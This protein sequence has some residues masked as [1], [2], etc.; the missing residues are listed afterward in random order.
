MFADLVLL[1]NSR[2]CLFLGKLKSKWIGSFL[3]TKMF[4][5]GAVEL[6]NKKGTKFTINGQK[7][8]IYPGHAESV[9]EVVEG[10][11]LDEI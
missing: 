4:S 6:D 11:H 2:L 9:H 1:L 8:K 5:H 3:I 7:I 10:Y